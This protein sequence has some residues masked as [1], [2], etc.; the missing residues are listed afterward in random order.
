VQ[1]VKIDVEGYELNVLRGR[2]EFVR[3]NRPTIFGEFSTSWYA[4]RALIR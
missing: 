2:E 4:A 3:R 1:R